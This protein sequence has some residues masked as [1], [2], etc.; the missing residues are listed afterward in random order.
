MKCFYYSDM[1]G[2]GSSN[3]KEKVIRKKHPT[4]MLLKYRLGD[5]IERNITTSN[6]SFNINLLLISDNSYLVCLTF[7]KSFKLMN[8]ELKAIEFNNEDSD[9]VREYIILTGDNAGLNIPVEESERLVNSLT[10]RINRKDHSK[11]LFKYGYNNINLVNSLN[12]GIKCLG[13]H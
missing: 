2:Y 7:D 13:G 1:V 5:D 8:E 3:I 10:D 6:Y 4:S 11:P 9:N 12:K